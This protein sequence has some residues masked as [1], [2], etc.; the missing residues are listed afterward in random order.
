MD[1]LAWLFGWHQDLRPATP[2]AE[3]H[4]TTPISSD[5]SATASNRQQPAAHEASEAQSRIQPSSIPTAETLID[6]SRHRKGPIIFAAGLA[7]TTISVFIT[8]RSLA[9]RHLASFSTQQLRGSKST[10]SSQPVQLSGAMEAV[11]ALNVATVNVLS[12]AML[13]TGGALWYFDISSVE[14]ARNK[15]RGGLGIDGTGRTEAEAEEDF[16]EWLATVLSRKE[17]KQRESE[18]EA[19]WRRLK[20]VEMGKDV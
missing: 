3:T 2:V 17:A 5:V 7:F 14:D 6:S 13:A 18:Y 1:K 10:S 11:E 12:L 8:R 16:E 4:S 15:V 20:N 9:R 19:K